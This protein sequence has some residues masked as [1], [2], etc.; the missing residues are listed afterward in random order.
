MD[1]DDDVS[2]DE[3]FIDEEQDYRKRNNFSLT[4]GHHNA[5]SSNV[6]AYNDA[7][8]G[9]G[10]R[11]NARSLNPPFSNKVAS[12][13]EGSA[14]HIITDSSYDIPAKSRT[15]SHKRA[16]KSGKVSTQRL[17]ITDT[18]RTT[19][20]NRVS[21][22]SFLNEINM[23]MRGSLTSYN[24]ENDSSYWGTGKMSNHVLHKRYIVFILCY[25]K[26]FI[27]LDSG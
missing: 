14:I 25:Q 13:T 12:L 9:F 22:S 16:K 17:D 8:L 26:S 5:Y 23:A 6:G 18:D 1:M 15:S 24:M 10:G 27:F 4:R 7:L 3:L 11:G 2:P 20:E 19:A 21:S